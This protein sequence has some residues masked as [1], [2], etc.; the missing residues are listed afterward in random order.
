[1]FFNKVRKNQVLLNKVDGKNYTVGDKVEGGFEAVEQLPKSTEEL[2]FPEVITQNR[3]EITEKNAIAFKLIDDPN[4]QEKPE[5]YKINNG[6]FVTA[7]GEKVETGELQVNNILGVV[8]G[9]VVLVTSKGYDGMSK[10]ISIY[11]PEKDI[12]KSL[13]Q[14]PAGANYAA[15]SE[16]D[17]MIIALSLNEVE[18]DEMGNQVTY[19]RESKVY[20]VCGGTWDDYNIPEPI[21]INDLKVVDDMIVVK[22]IG[23]VDEKNI[24]TEGPERI[25]LIDMLNLRKHDPITVNG[26]SL[27]ISR[28]RGGILVVSDKM[29]V[30]DTNHDRYFVVTDKCAEMAGLTEVVDITLKDHALRI[31]LSNKDLTEVK[32][33]VKTRSEDKGAI[34]TVE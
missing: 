3:V 26:R 19:L 2:P 20:T 6:D 10:H 24:I 32:T 4:P 30:V 1:M 34:Y 5:G 29:L 15:Y 13:F 28:S 11:E 8:P 31:T 17:K 21:I 22:T 16:G 23:D 33:L 7:E 27:K 18:K 12:F 9:A 25:V 14:I